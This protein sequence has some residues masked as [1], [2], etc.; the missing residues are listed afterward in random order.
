MENDMET[1]VRY[2]L[3]QLLV[4]VSLDNLGEG[5][6]LSIEVSIS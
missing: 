6:S 2:K 4:R 3:V 5:R 1:Y